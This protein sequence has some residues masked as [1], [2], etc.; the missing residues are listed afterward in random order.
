MTRPSS[1]LLTKILATVGPACE[2][3]HTLDRLI[4]EGVRVFRLNF[5]HGALTEHE[6]RLNAIRQAS[7]RAGIPVGVLGDLSGP[8]IRVGKVREGGI[9][10]AVGD[11]IEFQRQPMIA[12]QDAQ[13]G[14]A[15]V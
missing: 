5:S 9:F 4:E 1:I 14:R 2:D 11:Q 12:G 7:E 8:K 3:P 6:G 10:L 13:I 15:H